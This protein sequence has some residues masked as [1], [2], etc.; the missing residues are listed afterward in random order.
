MTRKQG[1]LAQEQHYKR[2]GITCY[3]MSLRD[4]SEALH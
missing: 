2:L 3:F 1:S 4:I